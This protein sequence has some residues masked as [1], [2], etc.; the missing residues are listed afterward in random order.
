MSC[1]SAADH[2]L[3]EVFAWRPDD[4]ASNIFLL[5]RGKRLLRRWRHRLQTPPSARAQH[6]PE[7][8]LL[9]AVGCAQEIR[10]E[11]LQFVRAIYQVDFQSPIT[12]EEH[13]FCRPAGGAKA[14]EP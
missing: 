2:T 3:R 11:T 10:F 14:L 13:S 8:V 5:A 7:R 4:Y 9:L 1:T 6:Q 12:T